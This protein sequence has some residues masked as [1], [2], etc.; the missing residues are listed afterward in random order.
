M[1]TNLEDLSTFL[2]VC[3]AGSMTQAAGILQVSTN[4]VSHR[5]Q[6]L[7]KNLGVSLLQRTTRRLNPSLEGQKLLEHSRRIL[8]EM[9]A[10][11][12]D[13]SQKTEEVSGLVRLGLPSGMLSEYVLR[14]LKPLLLAHPDLKLQIEIFNDPAEVISRSFDLGITPFPPR[15]MALKMRKIGIVSWK[16]CASVD[17]LQQFGQPQTPDELSQHHCLRFLSSPAQSEWTLVDKQGKHVVV[18]VRGPL[19]C[20]DSRLLGD[21]VYAGLGIGVRPAREIAEAELTGRLLP[22]LPDFAFEAL[23]ILVLYTAGRLK[24]PRV[25][26]LLEA[27]TEALKLIE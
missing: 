4:A 21:A 22:V 6:R 5:I 12:Q 14:Q 27:L 1:K 19:E 3:D 7:E 11:L 9:E 16:L 24:I 17:Y 23:D 13:V 26:V 18:P 20:S 25:K 15:D 2:V 8:A 10:L